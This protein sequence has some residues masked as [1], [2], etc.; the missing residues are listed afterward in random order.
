M[1]KSKAS[2]RRWRQLSKIAL[3]ALCVV[4]L[5]WGEHALAIDPTESLSEL[6]HTEWTARDGAPSTIY[7]IAQTS[8]GYL[9]LGT[10]LGLY[11][12]DGVS[13]ERPA[14]LSDG[15]SING[16]VSA[17]YATTSGDLWIGMRFGGAYLLRRGQV[18]HYFEREGLPPHTV[19]AFAA[20]PDGAIWAVAMTGLYRFD[21]NR[22]A[23][24]GRG[25]NY[26]ATDSYAVF[27]DRDGTLWARSFQGTF[28]LPKGAKEFEKSPVPGGRSWIFSVPNGSVWASD[29]DRGLLSLAAPGRAVANAALGNPEGTAAALV[30]RDGGLW[31]SVIK[32]S[33]AILVRIPNATLFLSNPAQLTAADIQTLGPTESLTAGPYNM[34]EDREGNIWMVSLNGL[35]RFS[36]NKLHSVLVGGAS[37]HLPAMT[38]DSA[39]TL[40]LATDN[41]LVK[42]SNNSAVPF[43]DKRFKAYDLVSCMLRDR[44]GSTLLGIQ[45][46]VLQRYFNGKMKD[47][48][49]WPHASSLA[50]Q[51]LTR[52]ATGGLWVS[53]AKD[54][55]YRQSATGWTRNGNLHGLPDNAPVTMLS[56][57]TGKL[58][59]G[60]PSDEVA[61]V[62]NNKVQVLGESQG[63]RVGVVLVIA[64]NRGHIWVGG[65][66]NVAVYSRGRFWSLKRVDGAAAFT[67][68]SGIAEGE[69]GSL[70]LNG[71]TG[72]VRVSSSEVAAFLKAPGRPVGAE[73]MNYEDGLTG[74]A[75]QVRPVPTALE[76]GDGRI[77][78]ATT[79]GAFWIDPTHIQRNRLP[80]P[81]F[82]K[83]IRANGRTY[84]TATPID[85]PPHTTSLEITY[86]ALSLSMPS[87]VHFKYKLEGVDSEWQDAGS[88]RQSFYTNVSPG[89]HRFLVTA[90]NEDG[91]W[92]ETP[93]IVELAIAPTFYQTRAFYSACA[94]AVMALLWQL[95][96]FRV[97]ILSRQMKM[98]M[99]ERLEERERIA[100]ELHDTLLQS[101]QGLILLFQ[102]FAG[103]LVKS[104]P[105]RGQMEVALDQ[106]DHLLNE[107][108]DRVSDLR[109]SGIDSDIPRALGSYADELFADKSI[110]FRT[111]TVGTPRALAFAV[112]DDVYRIGR[113]ALTN[114]V[115]HA[116]AGNVE[117]ES[118]YETNQFRMRVRDDGRGLD[119]ALLLAGGRPH[120]FGLQGMR[121][122]ARRIGGALE[123]WSRG[124][125][126][127]EIELTVP[128]SCAYAG[129]RSA[130]SRVATIFTFLK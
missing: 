82:V 15:S 102:G 130:R 42:F 93:A 7:A 97:R 103:R 26:S 129:Y 38:V 95:Y 117:L 23:L 87:R 47:V 28:F 56:D 62:Q 25:W 85:L 31:L 16:N 1:K 32:H 73:T 30:D 59:L 14:L 57:T 108:R 71:S 67:G 36:P 68:V 99:G 119:P 88:R 98:R 10:S 9:W 100:R 48:P 29:P 89:P 94:L 65:S 43:M 35:D 116:K 54:G 18:T 112:A 60:Y 126:G 120:H 83:S 49:L 111:V 106:A 2:P 107:A 52:D 55:L 22:W 115:V 101:T 33:T 21:G 109:T 46:A 77:W 128:A 122:R 11:R 13:F 86:T 27:V 69:D 51:A 118:A 34:L 64:E 74:V 6:R 4:A 113:E 105:M 20:T 70:W 50:I 114:A 37:L 127:T 79:D 58:W 61:V 44:D 17:L 40:W 96:R 123:I 91:V 63:L 41:E 81:V 3:R 53:A 76:S 72:V 19:F 12:F 80:P 45:P 5:M 125:T 104:D 124:G 39:G 75:A 110:G 90:A 8:D 24:V 121:E 66:D 84:S 92:N 78:F